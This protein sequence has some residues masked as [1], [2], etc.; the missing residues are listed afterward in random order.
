[1]KKGT[2]W[3]RKRL[4]AAACIAGAV[5][6][7]LIAFLC[8]NPYG[9]GEEPDPTEP[10]VPTT[11]ATEPTQESSTE[12]TTEP[13][14]TEPVMLEEFVELYEQNPDIAG[15]IR[16]DGTVVDYPVMYTP[17]DEEKYIH[18]DFEGNYDTNG[19]PF[20]AGDCS[21]DPESD[22]LII[23]GH[24]MMSG[25][26][27]ASLL[28]YAYKS[29]WKAH[30]IIEFSTLYENRQYEIVAA[31]YDR[32]YTKYYTGF[33]YYQFID[34]EDEEHFQAAMDYYKDKACYETGVEAEYGDRLIT[35]V[36][37]SWHTKYGR[38][39]V[40]GREVKPETQIPET[41]AP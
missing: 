17:E 13:E 14:P 8:W 37:C 36:T 9:W 35:L 6:I 10:T 29:Y 4:I 11:E 21:L 5:L 12:E 3:T 16:I 20:I 26:M 22:N 41:T 39:V 2:F 18:A 30:P 31:F 25:K 32:L 24:N 19:V 33:K 23:H 7:L 1:M 38:F 40:V 15:W 34:A 28:N 27:F